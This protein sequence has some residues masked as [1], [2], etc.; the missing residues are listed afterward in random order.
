MEKQNI[1]IEE[2]KENL[3]LYQIFNFFG[4]KTKI[5]NK[6]CGPRP[7]LRNSQNHCKY[8]ENMIFLNAKFFRTI[9]LSFFYFLS[10]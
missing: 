10:A 9:S 6:K 3:F 5:K 2:K 4:E 8:V 1:Q 7:R